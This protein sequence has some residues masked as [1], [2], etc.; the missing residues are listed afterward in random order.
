MTNLTESPVYE[1]GV[2]RLETTT[3]IK[4][5]NPTFV[6]G[7]PTDGF[8]NAQAQ[9]LANEM[10]LTEDEVDNLFIFASTL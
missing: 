5:G 8:A 1:P 6:A 3:P 2:F 10:Q 7:D 4:G 9:Q